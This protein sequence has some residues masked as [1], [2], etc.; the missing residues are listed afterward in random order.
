[1]LFTTEMQLARSPVPAPNQQEIVFHVFQQRENEKKTTPKSTEE[2]SHS[3]A[4]R[5]IAC[6]KTEVTI[7]DCLRS[8]YRRESEEIAEK[9]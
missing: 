2:K 8:H 9:A 3:V 7:A 4:S 5:H 1:M 6:L